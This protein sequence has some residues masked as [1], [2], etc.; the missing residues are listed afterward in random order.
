M[1]SRSRKYMRADRCEPAFLFKT[2]L[3]RTRNECKDL[4]IG[5][6]AKSYRPGGMT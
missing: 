5:F 2:S 4:L 3:S 1:I 6:N